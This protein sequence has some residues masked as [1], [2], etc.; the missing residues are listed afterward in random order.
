MNAEQGQTARASYNKMSRVYGL[1]SNGSEKKFVEVAIRQV[2]RP[3][4]AEIILEPGFGTGQ[5]LAALA[6][7]V[8]GA[9]RVYGIDIS[10]GMVEATRRRLTRK[11]L[12][13]RAELVRGDASKMPYEDNFF[14]AVF[15]SFTLE[16][17]P[18]D[19]I[20]VVLLECARVLKENGR[21]CVACMSDTGKDGT[22]KRLY[23]RAHRKFPNFVDCRPI[24]ARKALESSGFDIAEERILSMWGLPVEIV[25]GR[26]G[27]RQLD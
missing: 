16:L 17:F 7:M 12:E 6:E 15:M 1:L 8:G 10:D 18:A 21:V 25:L 27:G 3:E 20:P 19:E 13:S 9:G 22:M 23:V 2:L 5:V 4:P 14:D 24:L 26:T 11:G